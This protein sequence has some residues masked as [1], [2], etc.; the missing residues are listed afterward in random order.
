MGSAA[1]AVTAAAQRTSANMC[2]RSMICFTMTGPENG[3]DYVIDAADWIYTEPLQRDP[4][5]SQRIAGEARRGRAVGDLSGIRAWPCGCRGV[6]P[7]VRRLGVRPVGR[8]GPGGAA[9]ERQ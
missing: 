9:A 2:D 5:N 3:F 6:F 7:L 4:R 8:M 1:V